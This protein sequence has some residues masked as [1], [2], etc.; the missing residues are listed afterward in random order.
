VDLITELRARLAGAGLDAGPETIAWHLAHHH[1]SVVSGSS[2]SR[3]L[4]RA[5]LVVARVCGPRAPATT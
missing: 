3:T 1:D 4:T 2:I 5:G